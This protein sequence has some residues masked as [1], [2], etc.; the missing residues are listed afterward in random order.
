MNFGS[1]ISCGR[2]GFLFQEVKRA[3]PPIRRIE[4]SS[5]QNA[6]IGVS[7]N[8]TSQPLNVNPTVQIQSQPTPNLQQPKPVLSINQPVSNQ[9]N[10][11]QSKITEQ[12]LALANMALEAESSNIAVKILLLPI[13]ILKKILGFLYSNKKVA[14]LMTVPAALAVAL[15]PNLLEAVKTAN[16]NSAVATIKAI[17]QGQTTFLSTKS[18]CGELKELEQSQLVDGSIGGGTKSGYLFTVNSIPGGCEIYAKPTKTDGLTATGNRSFY[19]S[20]R[21]N[22]LRVSE[23]KSLMASALSPVLDVNGSMNQENG[24]PQI[25]SAK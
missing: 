14:A 24:K 6:Q 5:N 19:F 12:D 10:V 11:V 25:A 1:A 7:S 20:S 2:C 13:T 4:S 21:D 23:D 9:Q 16:E 18:R 8:P 17:N 15:G 22:T 3:M